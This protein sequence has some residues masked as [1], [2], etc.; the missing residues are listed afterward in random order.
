VFTGKLHRLTDYRFL[1]FTEL[2]KVYIGIRYILSDN[3]SQ[4]ST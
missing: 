2:S 4:F 3:Y 1:K